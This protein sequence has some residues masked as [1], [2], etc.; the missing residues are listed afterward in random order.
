MSTGLVE[1]GRVGVAP[2]RILISGNLFHALDF[3]NYISQA[4]KF[5]T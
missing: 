4:A 5:V 2:S 3:M 1:R